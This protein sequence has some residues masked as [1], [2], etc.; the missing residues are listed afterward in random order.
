MEKNDFMIY[1]RMS[2][3]IDI[4]EDDYVINRGVYNG[5]CFTE[6]DWKISIYLKI[7]LKLNLPYLWKIGVPT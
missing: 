5:F 6:I 4:F 2:N 3:L 1:N 7:K